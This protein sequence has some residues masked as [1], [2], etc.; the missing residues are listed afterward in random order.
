MGKSAFIN[1]VSATAELGKGIKASKVYDA[2][3]A[4]VVD[5]DIIALIPGDQYVDK[6]DIYEYV[7][8]LVAVF[9]G[10]LE[11]LSK[12]L[13]AKSSHTYSHYGDCA[14]T[15]KPQV[16]SRTS[17]ANHQVPD[18]EMESA[19]AGFRF[20]AVV[21]GQDEEGKDLI[22]LRVDHLQFFKVDGYT[23]TWSAVYGDNQDVL[24][25]DDGFCKMK[26]VR[27]PHFVPAQ[28]SKT[29]LKKLMGYLAE[30]GLIELLAE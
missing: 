9:N 15:Q 8:H 23:W 2:I 19:S 24:I 11:P 29:Q 10:A 1:N 6:F 12:E 22:N 20:K 5:G 25:G 14:T 17:N 21:V 4:K 3:S 13:L 28:L 16:E 7:C 26:K 18:L 30:D 27:K